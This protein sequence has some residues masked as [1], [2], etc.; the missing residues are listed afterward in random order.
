MNREG[1]LQCL[2]TGGMNV[3]TFDEDGH[4]TLEELEMELDS[5]D[6][7]LTNE[8]IDGRVRAVR[9]A[10]NVKVLVSSRIGTLCEVGRHFRPR[11]GY[12]RSILWAFKTWGLSETRKRKE[13]ALEAAIRGFY[14]EHGLRIAKDKLRPLHGPDEP[15][16]HDSTVYGNFSRC[17]LVSRVY[18]Q[19]FA[20]HQHEPICGDGTIRDGHD[21]I[22]LKWMDLEKGT[23]EHRQALIDA[24][25]KGIPLAESPK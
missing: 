1:M 4:K 11:V 25:M 7:T 2:R 12:N 18:S 5:R 16:T 9:V 14:E 15:N 21:L 19:F 22:F 20:L 8:V 3:E 10:L 13:T 6:I 17:P 24:L 23:S